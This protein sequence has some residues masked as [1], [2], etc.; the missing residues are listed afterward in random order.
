MKNRS[1]KDTPENRKSLTLMSINY[2]AKL[3]YKKGN[4]RL[5]IRVSAHDL[6]IVNNLLR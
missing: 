1:V 4:N 2:K 6:K 5:L 3:D